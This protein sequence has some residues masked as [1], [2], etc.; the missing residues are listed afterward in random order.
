MR[1]QYIFFKTV[2]KVRNRF[3]NEKFG[4]S[5]KRPSIGGR[6]KYFSY[7]CILKGK[8]Y[9]G[10]KKDYFGGKKVIGGKK[11]F[12]GGKKVFF[13]GKK[14]ACLRN[15]SERKTDFVGVD[16]NVTHYLNY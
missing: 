12:F 1:V 6:R 7:K 5:L 11:D 8:F 9:I 3:I 14:V 16:D 4:Q 15:Q 13:G 2:G 10:D